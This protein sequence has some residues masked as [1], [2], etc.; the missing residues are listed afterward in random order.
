MILDGKA[1]A[2]RRIADLKLQIAELK[3]KPKLV[4]IIVGEDPASQMYVRMKN[5]R[6]QEVG[7]N[8]ETIQL[9][10]TSPAEMIIQS[11]NSLNKNPEVTGVLIQLP[12]PKD[13]PA[14]KNQRKIL[15]TIDPVK[16]VDC[17][18]SVNM[19][20]LAFGNPRYYPATVKGILGFLGEVSDIQHPVS[21]I[22]DKYLFAGK[23][24]VVVGRSNIVGK[25]MVMALTN[26]GATVTVCNSKTK[27]L[28]EHTK[29]A[30]ILISAA[31]VPGLITKDM[32]KKGAIVI[33][34]GISKIKTTA[35][36]SRQLTVDRMVGDVDFEAVKDIAGAITPV[37]GGVGPMTIVSLL[38]NTVE[39]LIK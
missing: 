17:L 13:S 10:N 23:S 14:G 32:V 25:P 37:P 7:I 3:I 35:V 29:N 22:E 38:E 1:I 28:A 16:D 6:A 12:F 20:L 33:D 4:A 26:L 27:N 39:A 21:S 30:D 15:D 34:A 36:E 19:G 18:T 2:A 9:A 11:I 5:K 8:S 31:G 24:A